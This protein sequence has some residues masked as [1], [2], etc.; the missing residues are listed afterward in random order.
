MSNSLLFLEK[1]FP[2]Q[3]TSWERLWHA[4]P[5]P[6]GWALPECFL[7]TVASTGS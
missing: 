3:A 5:S 4:L 7:Y 2:T 1:T 6:F